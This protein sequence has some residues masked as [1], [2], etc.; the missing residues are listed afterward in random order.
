MQVVPPDWT[1]RIARWA[2]R[3]S[4][5]GHS[6]RKSRW[7]PDAML[8]AHAERLFSEGY[9][10]VVTGHFHYPLL[11]ETD[12]KTL[13]ALGDWIDQFSY[14]VCEDGRFELR[15]TDLIR[16]SS[17]SGSFQPLFFSTSCAPVRPWSS[18][19]ALPPRFPIFSSTCE[20]PPAPAS[21]A[22]RCS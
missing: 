6:A 20:S 19:Q 7:L 12:G 1:W 16:V 15:P 17:A 9:E 8:T 5:K 11:R 18:F 2:G 3:Q 4:R 21:C 10:T 13:V 14:A 22:A